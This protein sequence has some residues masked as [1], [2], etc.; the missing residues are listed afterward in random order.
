M[1]K[2]VPIDKTAIH[3]VT[4]YVEPRLGDNARIPV[5]QY[6]LLAGT[7]GTDFDAGTDGEFVVKDERRRQ[8][9]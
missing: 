9:C 2:D 1:Y 7:A 8:G 3:I 5:T 4:R 6:P